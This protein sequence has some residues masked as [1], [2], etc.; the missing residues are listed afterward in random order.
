MRILGRRVVALSLVLAVVAT[1]ALVAS[2]GTGRRA[3]AAGIDPSLC[4]SST[5]SRLTVPTSYQLNLCW[6]GAKLTIKN[7]TEFVLGLAATGA[8]GTGTRTTANLDAAGLVI[9]RVD[10]SPAILP[11]GYQESVPVGA[12]GGEV[13]LSYDGQINSDYLLL[14]D[15]EGVI[16]GKAFS[17]FQAISTFVDTLASARSTYDQCTAGANFLTRAGCAAALTEHV[18]SAAGTFAFHA[19]IELT[20]HAGSLG[21]LVN[22]VEDGKWMVTAVSERHQLRTSDDR[23]WVAAIGGTSIPAPPPTTTTHPPATSIDLQQV[24]AGNY[25]S[26]QGVWKNNAGSTITISGVT[27]NPNPNPSDQGNA[28]GRLAP[29]W[30]LEPATSDDQSYVTDMSGQVLL[31]EEGTGGEVDVNSTLIVLQKGTALENIDVNGVK[32]PDPTDIMRDRLISF[33]AGGGSQPCPDSSCA[34]YRA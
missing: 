3:G 6:D 16:P 8:I 29:P 23:V 26:L 1:V 15:L 4:H 30:T 27:M 22:L 13:A 14:R 2:V 20:T 19:G 25:T 11:P 31:T 18:V 9:A 7:T 21:Q 17:S 10:H 12:D 28:P 33:D 32:Y 24:A 34:Y 5:T